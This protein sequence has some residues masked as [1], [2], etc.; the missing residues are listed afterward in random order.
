MIYILWKYL[1]S[2]YFIPSW[3][4]TSVSH[5]KQIHMFMILMFVMGLLQQINQELSAS[6]VR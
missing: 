3:N 4:Q 2:W 6:T 5:L 1:Y